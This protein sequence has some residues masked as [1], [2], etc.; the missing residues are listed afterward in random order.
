MEPVFYLLAVLR[1][2]LLRDCPIILILLVRVIQTPDNWLYILIFGSCFIK[3]LNNSATVLL[4][5]G[6]PSGNVSCPDLA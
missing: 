5:F 2:Q 1:M 4:F 6:C 3:S